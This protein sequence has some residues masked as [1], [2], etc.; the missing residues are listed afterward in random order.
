MDWD[1]NHHNGQSKQS[2]PD[3]CYLLF[4]ALLA[5]YSAVGRVI[6]ESIGKSS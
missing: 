3:L 1:Y 5:V 2:Y 6:S 4:S